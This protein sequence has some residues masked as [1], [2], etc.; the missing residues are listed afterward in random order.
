[1]IGGRV[2]GGWVATSLLLILPYDVFSGWSGGGRLVIHA[3]AVV[4]VGVM[5]EPALVSLVER[6]KH[7]LNISGILVC[8][9]SGRSCKEVLREVAT[10]APLL[11]LSCLSRLLLTFSLRLLLRNLLLTSVLNSQLRSPPR[12]ERRSSCLATGWPARRPVARHVLKLDGR[13]GHHVGAPHLQHPPQPL[14]KHPQHLHHV[15]VVQ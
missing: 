2:L 6:S 11:S 10:L 1:M 8:R 15:Q 12:G 9:C 4:P 5:D 14:L 3:K 7:S 13:A